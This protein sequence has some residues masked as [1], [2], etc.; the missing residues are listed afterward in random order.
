M[1]TRN[2]RKMRVG[3]VASNAMDKTAVVVVERL[4][5]HPQ[6]KKVIRRRKRVKVH[7]EQGVCQPGDLVRIMET[8]PLSKTKCWRYVETIRKAIQV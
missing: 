3:V 1:P 4:L 6:Y 7:D 2:R 5:T 8:R